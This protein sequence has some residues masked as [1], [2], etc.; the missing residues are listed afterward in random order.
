MIPS[1]LADLGRPG[2]IT[3]DVFEHP[4]RDGGSTCKIK[5]TR[6]ANLWRRP[7][8]DIYHGFGQGYDYP[9]DA[10]AERLAAMGFWVNRIGLRGRNGSSDIEGRS[11]ASG[12]ELLDAWDG[13]HALLAEYGDEISQHLSYPVGFSGG[14]GNVEGIGAKMPDLYGSFGAVFFA[15][16][17]YG[18]PGWE[19]TDPAVV[20]Q[21]GLATILGGTSSTV[22]NVYAARDHISALLRNLMYGPPTAKL[23]LFH[24]ASD[25]TVS[26]RHSDAVYARAEEL[27]ITSRVI[28]HRSSLADA[29][30]WHH[31]YP[32]D[33]PDLIQAE[34]LWTPDVWRA[35]AWRFP[36]SSSANIAG[37]R[38]TRDSG[39]WLAASG[40][41]DPD[42]AATCQYQA[43]VDQRGD[44]FVVTPPPGA[45]ISVRINRG[46][47]SVTNTAVTGRTVL[48]AA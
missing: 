46:S 41:S 14:G 7:R 8:V 23:R 19:Q 6:A 43:R 22:P 12:R 16:I 37:Y 47:K 20:T 1:G 31:G 36:A 45:T 30:R 33:Q 21:A 40:E 27:G 25:G 44:E 42:E 11:D 4:C 18:N 48:I 17:R 5:V 24:D 35:R 9:G 10:T 39:V 28:Y 2:A 38:L 26:I 13:V 29:V 3:H 34:A 32:E 15:I